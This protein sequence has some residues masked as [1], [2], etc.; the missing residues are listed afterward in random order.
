MGL[1]EP[2]KRQKLSNDPR[3]L[4][5]SSQSSATSY[6]HRLMTQQGWSQGQALGKRTTTSR[7]GAPSDAERLAAAQVGVLFKDDNLG[8]GAK[9]KS[10]KETVEDQKVG[11]DAFQGLLGRLNG[12]SEEVLK[13]EEKKIEDRKLEMYARGRWGG[14][15]FV[16]GGVLVGTI[17]E[18]RRVEDIAESSPLLEDNKSAAE[19]LSQDREKATSEEREERQQLKEEK[20]RR[21]EERR[22]RREEKARR[23]AAKKARD[24]GQ[25][26]PV[27]KSPLTQPP[28]EPM[29]SA[30]S[31][32]ETEKPQ[33]PNQSNGRRKHES[34]K[35]NAD[36][37][38]R[39][40]SVSTLVAVPNK[41]S[42]T[43]MKTGRHL[44]RGRN[45][46][47]KKM[48]MADMKGLDEIFMR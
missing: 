20:R 45:I 42:V 18:K 9:R 3:N 34:S 21:K 35:H 7:F 23:R 2:R 13:R 26:P 16:K 29:S 6:G 10:G 11:L 40:L 4:A 44:L 41:Q 43:V 17:D 19:S 5:W 25:I 33:R 30:A 39:N 47:A 28:D 22:I 36:T 46:Q 14:M 38:E 37:E 8:L 15:I 31:N 32:D 1:A 27:H 24:D 12:K 48:V